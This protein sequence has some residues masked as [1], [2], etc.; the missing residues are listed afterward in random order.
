[1]E[2][3]FKC[4]QI[5]CQGATS[6]TTFADFLCSKID[7]GLRLAIYDKTALVIAER[8]RSEIRDFNG[9]R[10]NL[11]VCILKYLAQE[12]NFEKF[13]LY[14][15]SPADFLESY[16]QTHVKTYCLDQNSRL[17]MFLNETLTQY[18]EEIQ[19][20]VFT[21]TTVVKDRIG[22]NKIIS[23]WLDEFC[24]E[25]GGVLRL[26]RSDLVGIEHLE[27]TDIEFLNNAMT[28]AL[29]PLRDRLKEEFA[30]A[31]LSSFEKQPHTI[32][33][34]HFPGCKE[35]CPFCWAVCTNTIPNHDGDHQLVFHRP[36]V[37]GR[38][39]WYKTD[40]LVI[41]IC[42]SSVASDCRFRI[43]EDKWIPYKKYRD[44]GHPFCTWNIL[45]DTSMQK[46]WKWFVSHFRAQLEELYNG[47][48]HGRGEIPASWHTITKQ[49]AL[50]EL[51]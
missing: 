40:N 21:S 42:S 14:I 31:D 18:Y 37:L 33:L 12:E 41:D 43:G 32:L 17:V 28:E 13:K 10:A 11:E 26:P 7:P 45:P 25:L 3:F 34:E 47:K 19:K 50:D 29:S 44:A 36:Q 51:R 24:R 35:Q 48:F 6:I 5:S 39:R 30:H 9:S 2:D 4:F 23:L 15:H 16:I 49:E 8:M 22:S 38:Y 27:I 46:Y 20:A 1:I